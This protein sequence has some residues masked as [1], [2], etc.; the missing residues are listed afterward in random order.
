MSG[1][2]FRHARY[3]GNQFN[4]CTIF[5]IG[6]SLVCL[7]CTALTLALE[8]Q[9]EI[10]L[11]PRAQSALDP[12]GAERGPKWGRH[13]KGAASA[14]IPHV[15]AAAAKRRLHE[16]DEGGSNTLQAAENHFETPH[17]RLHEP[18]LP[19]VTA[20]HGRHNLPVEVSTEVHAGG[21]DGHDK[22]G[23]LD[24]DPAHERIAMSSELRADA[25]RQS[26]GSDA[27]HAKAAEQPIHLGV[28]SITTAE[29]TERLAASAALHMQSQPEEEGESP[30]R[31]EAASTPLRKTTETP[32]PAGEDANIDEQETSKSGRK[33]VKRGSADPWD[34]CVL[35]DTHLSSLSRL[36]PWRAVQ[37]APIDGLGL[38]TGATSVGLVVSADTILAAGVAAQEGAMTTVQVPGN[39]LT[40]QARVL[41]AAPELQ[42]ALLEVKEQAFWKSLSN[43]G[44]NRINLKAGTPLPKRGREVTVAGFQGGDASR[45]D[46]MD[47]RISEV[48]ASSND[49]GRDAPLPTAALSLYPKIEKDVAVGPVFDAH[50]KDL[51]GFLG[52]DSRLIPMHVIATF[53]EQARSTKKAWP[54]TPTLGMVL[55]PMQG[56]GLRTFWG[57]RCSSC[58][59]Q[60]RDTDPGWSGSTQI[61]KGDF[62]IAV[63]GEELLSDGTMRY[64]NTE[65]RSVVLPFQAALG[66]KAPG[67]QTTFKIARP[68]AFVDPPKDADHPCAKAHVVKKTTGMTKSKDIG[69][70]TFDE[71]GSDGAAATE[72]SQ[73]P[74]S[75]VEKADGAGGGDASG[76]GPAFGY[77]LSKP[78][79]VTV[80]LRPAHTRRSKRPPY[81]MVGGLVFGE[82]SA[83]L[84]LEAD[85]DNNAMVPERVQVEAALHWRSQEKTPPVVLLQG[86][87]HPCNKFYPKKSIRILES[88]NGD[89]FQGLTDLL[90]RI[91]EALREPNQR[92]LAFGLQ[93]TD[94]KDEA[95]QAP[96]DPDIVLDIPHCAGADSLLAK[97]EGMS[98]PASRDLAAQYKQAI[99]RAFFTGVNF[100]KKAKQFQRGSAEVDSGS[101]EVEV[102]E[103]RPG[104][105]GNHTRPAAMLGPAVLSFLQLDE[106]DG[107]ED[108]AGSDDWADEDFAAPGHDGTPTAVQELVK[109]LEE[110]RRELADADKDVAA[111][112][113]DA[114]KSLSGGPNVLADDLDLASLKLH[115]AQNRLSGEAAATA[116][117]PKVAHGDDKA[118]VDNHKPNEAHA[119]PSAAEKTPTAI[120]TAE[121]PSPADKPSQKAVTEKHVDEKPFSE[122]HESEKPAKKEE[123]RHPPAVASTVVL[124]KD[125]IPWG[126]VV[127]IRFTAEK[128]DFLTPWKRDGQTVARCSGVIVNKAARQI[129][130]N[131]HCVASSVSLDVMREDAP[132]PVPARVVEIARDLDLA[133]ITT[134]EE[135]FWQSAAIAP[136]L[137]ILRQVPPLSAPVRVV[138]YPIGGDSITITSG[139]LSRIDAMQLSLA[140]VKSARNTPE[141]SMVIQV[142]AAINPGNSGGPVF[143][144]KGMLVGLAFA[145]MDNTQ[146]VGYVISTIYLANFVS[147]VVPRPREAACKNTPERRWEAQ[148]ETGLLLRKLQNI[149]MRSYLGLQDDQTGVQVRSV[150]PLSLLYNKLKPFD[151]LTEVDGTQIRG[152]GTITWELSGKKVTMPFGTRITTKAPGTP[153]TLQVLRREGDAKTGKLRMFEV[154]VAFKPVPPLIP[155][156][157]DSPLGI[158][159]REHFAAE[160]SYFI[161][162]GL[163][164]GVASLPLLAEAAAAEK[165]GMLLPWSVKTLLLH[166]WLTREDEQVVVLLKGLPHPCSAEYDAKMLRV[167]RYFNG[168]AVRN[169]THLASLVA[170]AEA[171]PAESYLR[172]TYAPLSDVRVAGDANDPDVVLEKSTCSSGNVQKVLKSMGV[173]ARASSDVQEAFQRAFDRSREGSPLG[174]SAE[175]DSWEEKGDDAEKKQPIKKGQQDE[176]A[177]LEIADELTGSVLAQLS[178]GERD[179]G[180]ASR[181]ESIRYLRAGRPKA[182]AA[183]GPADADATNGPAAHDVSHNWQ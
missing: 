39:S 140:L 72:G 40:F 4:A 135:S 133:W 117:K 84:L 173:P 60:V 20:H 91:G 77:E 54:G 81:V 160:A 79:D 168:K 126:N 182:G 86:L 146:S 170:R 165:H 177:A 106:S 156:F 120:P 125:D 155:R 35:V 31:S 98:F 172:F 96:G 36:S 68:V 49:A 42:L 154:K 105:A 110:A 83:E 89:R 163:V 28:D 59:M 103:K 130:T 71:D 1:G 29:E 50:S 113:S 7:F 58:G 33:A 41:T 153:T 169:L 76:C 53:F 144:E 45:L 21:R 129:L 26:E 132:D 119:K 159:G 124:R 134:D 2:S 99:P 112:P 121:K 46:L 92:Y 118:S 47:S 152:D 166:R 17:L 69:E 145:G 80:Q 52:V 5:A 107:I 180:H 73:A 55:R 10:F 101:E 179:A 131:S 32:A 108:T 34:N 11:L 158:A 162:G 43:Y 95:S 104:D 141:P 82:L 13:L 67:S 37:A 167:L 114:S 66:E 25:S 93:M 97:R 88:F 3:G 56:R 75:I 15:P 143:D 9:R 151:V 12:A 61:K 157:D 102:K 30:T 178:E 181:W 111:H 174:G 122:G 14:G 127:Q 78:F 6:V 164:W 175:D 48:S 148:P 22:A 64:K 171:D 18:P 8:W 149:G 183:L 63:D 62:V 24:N 19:S 150:A 139:I 87:E 115:E 116:P 70:W 128:Q 38:V 65:D 147:S 51:L 74:E 136:Q 85:A 142:D 57:M 123:D 16:R 137:E 90:K 109:E 161:T 23:E 138:G 100:A 94:D 27:L 44:R 176:P